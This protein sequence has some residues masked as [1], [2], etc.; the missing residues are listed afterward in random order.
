M[1]EQAIELKNL[2]KKFS[3]FTAV[4]DPSLKLE[5]GDIFGFLGPTGVEKSTTIR[6]F[7]TLAQTTPG[8]AKAV[9]Y[10]LIKDSAKVRENIRLVSGKMIM[11]EKFTA[12]ENLRFFRKIYV[13]PKAEAGSNESTLEYVFLA[14]TG[15]EMCEPCP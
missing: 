5:Q 3:D 13:I 9:D 15:K 12:A 6:M 11:Y 1:T 4:E 14:V 8:S 10:D 7:R 2:T